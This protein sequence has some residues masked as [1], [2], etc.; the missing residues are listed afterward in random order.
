MRNINLLYPSVIATL[1]ASHI[2]TLLASRIF[3]WFDLIIVIYLILYEK[4]DEKNYIWISIIFGLY[5][6]YLR[7]GFVGPAVMLFLL[8][9]Y[10]RFKVDLA[11]DM[12]KLNSK[13]LLYATASLIYSLFNGIMSGYG[14]EILAR[15]VLIRTSL[16]IVATFVIIKLAGYII[17]FK[18]S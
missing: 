5:S 3:S 4:I 17:A 1:V 7:G 2:L 11:I 15:I 10:S 9:S 8:F 18:N 16:D 13:M 12:T 14:A 6:D